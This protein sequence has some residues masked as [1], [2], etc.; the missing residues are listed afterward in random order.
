M[1]ETVTARRRGRRNAARSL[2][3]RA[4]DLFRN[5]VLAASV[6]LVGPWAVAGRP[7][8]A[9]ENTA[10]ARSL[11][12]I[13][14]AHE[15]ARREDCKSVLKHATPVLDRSGGEDLPDDIRAFAYDL[16]VVCAI[17]QGQSQRALTYARLGS[18]LD[19]S[20]D[21][22]WHMRFGLL[23]DAEQHEAA[24]ETIEAMSQ[25]RGAALNSASLDWVSSLHRALKDAGKQEHRRRL[26][27]VLS[28]EA[29]VPEASYG[30]PD[31]YR[32]EYAIMLATAGET[33]EARVMLASIQEP[34]TMIDA[35]LDSRVRQLVPADLDIRAAAEA[36]LAMRR[37]DMARHPDRLRPRLA[38]AGDL[39][40][41]GRPKEAIELL[42]RVADRIGSPSFFEDGNETVNWWWDELGRSHSA[43]G[44]YEQAATAFGQGA[45]IQEGR[46]L[47]VSQLIN[48]AHHHIRFGRAEEALKTLAA[49]DDPA[50]TTSPYGMMEMRL[51]R[52]CAQVV[53]GRPEAA[54]ADFAYMKE[55]EADHPQALIEFYLCRRDLDE[56]SAAIIRLLDDPEHGADALRQLSD[57]A[58]PPA[59]LAHDPIEPQLMMLKQRADVRAAIAR[60][61]GVRRFNVQKAPL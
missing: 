24:V 6:A 60:A 46:F 32:L 31:H 37:D 49:F 42:Q 10:A 29:Y 34:A 55:H 39:R 40:M 36:M 5:L 1:S 7:A 30:P 33:D 51:A 9:G 11:R 27:K 17:R 19:A 45:A 41:L 4:P 61:G 18:E 53:A 43:L 28:S 58:D 25:G 44:D 20:S 54:E 8:V 52:A 13:Q 26:L 47:N 35:S 21:Y 12:A 3:C 59:P 16:V 38:A 22:L 48:L 15:A 57:Y 23:L 50:R 56:A 2:A 14:H